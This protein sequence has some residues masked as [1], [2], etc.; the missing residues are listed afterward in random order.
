M[1]EH[2]TDRRHIALFEASQASVGPMGTPDA[3]MERTADARLTQLPQGLAEGFRARGRRATMQ[4]ALTGWGSISG[5]GAASTSKGWT[6]LSRRVEPIGSV[7]PRNL[8]TANNVNRFYFRVWH[9]SEVRCSAMTSSG[10]GGQADAYSALPD[11]Q[12]LTHIHRW[13]SGWCGHDPSESQSA[14]C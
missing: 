10:I 6:M 2:A 11:R 9:D 1:V 14:Q 3:L 4:R 7:Q 13:R 12:E 5:P 8:P